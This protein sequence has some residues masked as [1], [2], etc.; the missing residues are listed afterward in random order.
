M[1]LKGALEKGRNTF[2][3]GQKKCV[4]GEK[5]TGRI[6]ARIFFENGGVKDASWFD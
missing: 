5:N 1:A 4:V 2:K 3:K 6:G